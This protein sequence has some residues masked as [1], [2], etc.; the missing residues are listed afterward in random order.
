MAAKFA[1]DSLAFSPALVLL[2]KLAEL[3]PISHWFAG[4]REK[5]VNHLKKAVLPF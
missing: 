5:N 4:K 2:V 3:S 1:V